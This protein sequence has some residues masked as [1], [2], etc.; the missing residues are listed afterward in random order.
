MEE[1][2]D[3]GPAPTA[4]GVIYDGTFY[5]A[6][7]NSL[8]HEFTNDDEIVLALKLNSQAVIQS[9]QA[10]T[11]N[12]VINGRGVT[13]YDNPTFAVELLGSDYYLTN[14]YTVL[15]GD[16]IADLVTDT[17]AS[18][19]TLGTGAS[20]KDLEGRDFDLD[21]TSVSADGDFGSV[22]ILAPFPSD[23]PVT[24]CATGCDYET[25][26]AWYAVVTNASPGDSL[27]LDTFTNTLN[28][29]GAGTALLPIT[30]T[31][32]DSS[33]VATGAWTLDEDYW[34]I[35]G[36]GGQ[37]VGDVTV[38]GTKVIIDRM[39]H[40]SIVTLGVDN[41]HSNSL[42]PTGDTLSIPEGATGVA[43]YND[44]I[45]GTLSVAETCALLKNLIVVTADLSGVGAGE[46]ATFTN[47]VFVQS[48]ATIEGTLGVDGTA[49]F[50]DCQFEVA[51]ANI[52]IDAAGDDYRI[53]GTS[54]CRNA[55]V[56]VSLTE[57]IRGTTVPQG[58]VPCIG[59]YEYI[60]PVVIMGN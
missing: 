39:R 34:T 56:D 12:L 17:P 55:G 47:C 11:W 46:T 15:D 16:R 35:N 31:F 51:A 2:T 40:N 7:V 10:I 1:D 25:P 28:A 50:N 57:D 19:I 33:T 53:K 48:Q 8:T 21:Y 44:T 14:R 9:P 3:Q 42:I 32:A 24:I 5:D 20:V 13:S 41:V 29:T 30:I 27:E 36:E 4:F 26:A 37:I 59:A 43:V 23:N 58:T 49:V 38:T 60:A 22:S 6:A 52:F 45:A 18:A 54:V